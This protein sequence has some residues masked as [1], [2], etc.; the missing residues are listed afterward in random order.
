MKIQSIS[1]SS[2]AKTLEE[3]S[4]VITT[5]S[6]LPIYTF[7][8]SEYKNSTEAIITNIQRKFK[9]QLLVVR[10]SSINEDGEDI[11]NAGHFESILNVQNNE[12]KIKEAIDTVIGSYNKEFSGDE[13]FVQPQLTNITNA[14]VAFTSDLDT[15]APYYIINF[16]ES[17][18]TDS[19]TSGTG[20][21]LKTFIYFKNSPIACPDKKIN[22][23]IVCLKEL[24]EIFN[25]PHLDVEFAF[26]NDQLYIFQVRRISTN[27]KEDLSGIDLN[28]TLL[29]IHKKITKLSAAHPNLLGDKAIYGVMPDWNPAEIIGLKPKHLAASLYKEI[30]TDSIW[31]YQRDNYGYRN[32]R[33]HPLMLLYLGV[34]YI[35]VRVDFNSFI[36]KE[37]D[38]KIAKKLVDHYLTKLKSSPVLH[39][40]VEFEIV[41]SCF[42]FNLPEKLTKDLKPAGFN[43]E[44]IN[45]IERSL[46]SITNKIIDPG[47][48][49]YKKD[50]AQAEKLKDKYEKIVNSQLSLV[51]KIYWLLEDCKRYGTLP[52]A[53]VAR[54]A[55]IATQFLRSFV[56]LEI[57]TKEE[58]N[59]YTGSLNTVTKD[60]N[61]DL[62]L[63]LS[64]KITKQE[65][66]N[67][68]G[69]LRPGTYDILSLR[70]DE[71]FENYFSNREPSLIEH[72]SFT[73]SKKQLD[74]IEALIKKQGLSISAN[75]LI[76]FIKTSIEGRESVKFLFTRSLSKVLSLIE[77][78]AV[79]YGIKREDLVYMDIKTFIDLY[80]S[81]DYR[82][83]KEIFERDIEKNKRT[84][85][86]TKAVK[87]PSLISDPNDVYF[88][89]LQADEPNYITLKSIC[90]QTVSQEN[91]NNEILDNKIIFIRS[92]DPGFDFL[93]TKNIGGLVTQFG[94]A[95]SHMAVRCAE[96]G[97]PA[98]IGAGETNFNAW[99]SAKLLEVD[100]LNK[101]VKI[102]S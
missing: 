64:K 95:N 75:L 38:E 15:L 71:N 34:P 69:H 46:L 83:V 40:K 101:I 79:K 3:L 26:S 23:L 33:S 5:A 44:E 18:S 20:K 29:K 52:F 68:Y 12:I 14:G 17:G 49:L 10:S 24:E 55:F 62:N 93:F 31:A 87:L 48:G 36:P 27:K 19:V 54:S 11:S 88:H 1:F 90:S 82:D 53:G 41:H 42:Y 66:L 85:R 91:V 37:L 76:E 98:V 28:E 35:D 100:C 2:K 6:V 96:L 58:Y 57:L 60:L 8:V 86:Y 30:I 22:K 67:N 25:F 39:D 51:D 97:I 4:Q 21:N 80:A 16:D 45:S 63:F 99:S 9:D 84:Y 43:D 92:A 65:F 47:V 73:F 72:N 61:N 59:L 74:K 102:I 13:V 50:L 70:Y 32:L 81:L 7:S 77:E 56:D 89:F 78:L 94:G